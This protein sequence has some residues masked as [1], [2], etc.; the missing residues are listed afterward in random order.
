[1][2]EIYN[3]SRFCQTIDFSTLQCEHM[4]V[5]IF[6]EF[7][8][9]LFIFVALF[10]ESGPAQHIIRKLERLV[11]RIDNPDKQNTCVLFLA[12][13]RSQDKVVDAAK[14][15][16]KLVYYRKPGGIG[17]RYYKPNT[18]GN[19]IRAGIRWFTEKTP[20]VRPMQAFQQSS[21]VN[22]P[23]DS[24]PSTPIFDFSGLKEK[25]GVRMATDIDLLL[26]INDDDFIVC[27]FK[28]G[29][30]PMPG[31]QKLAFERLSRA[32]R[33]PTIHFSHTDGAGETVRAEDA[34]AKSAY[35]PKNGVWGWYP[36]KSRVPLPR[37]VDQATQGVL[38]PLVSCH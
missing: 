2:S 24:S 7:D 9:R 27:E 31:G 34:A 18:A 38:P 3:L 17:F 28:S 1:M 11:G 20:G 33:V 26:S 29:D 5:P 6:C 4:R 23:D 10:D 36:P 32:A 19:S 30:A 22:V 14:L 8:N 16:V 35:F 15:P 21:F 25:D 13:Y 12:K 37:V